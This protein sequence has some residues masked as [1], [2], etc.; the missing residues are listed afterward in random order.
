MNFENQVVL[1]VGASSGMGRVV[2]LKL[3]AAGA[4]LVVTARRKERL[5]S[6]AA[7]IAARGGECLALPADALDERAAESVVES[8]VERFGRIDVVLL[9]A[10]GAPAIDMRTMSAAEVKSYMRTNYDVTVNYLFP[11]LEQMKA[12][13]SGFVAH[14]N[15]LAGFL[16]VPLQGPYSAAKGAVRLLMDTCR[17]EFA[18]YGI[19][20]SSIYPGFVGTERTQDDGMPAP[21]EI[22]EE[23]GADHILYA[24]RKEKSDYLFPLVMRWLIRLARVLPKP[25]VNRILAREV[26]PLEESPG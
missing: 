24:L 9:N 3:A 22:S 7:E 2:A 12:Q 10:G 6:L 8:A 15:S 23:K 14:T 4:K 18:G 17:V 16:G 1:I 25:V 26:P 21:L 11:V 19:K 13:R 5:E 20:F